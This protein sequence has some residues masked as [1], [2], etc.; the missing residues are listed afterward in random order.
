[1]R[2]LD[3][4]PLTGDEVVVEGVRL[5]VISTEGHRIVSLRAMP[6]KYPVKQPPESGDAEQHDVKTDLH[7]GDNND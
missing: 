6:E 4:P 1:M 7:E 5:Q 2:H 3:R